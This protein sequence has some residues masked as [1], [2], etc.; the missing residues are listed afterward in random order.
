MAAVQVPWRFPRD[1][2]TGQEARAA[3]R[4]RS[5][6]LKERVGERLEQSVSAARALGKGQLMGMLCSSLL[7]ADQGAAEPPELLALAEAE[8]GVA[9]SSHRARGS[10]WLDSFAPKGGLEAVALTT[11]AAE[12]AF[13]WWR[14]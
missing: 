8:A 10:M 2:G 4:D 6:P 14:P 12:A 5:T 9:F 13:D 3:G 11:P 1:S 7:L